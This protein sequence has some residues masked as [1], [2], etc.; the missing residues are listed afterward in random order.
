[1]EQREEVS[2]PSPIPSPPRRIGRREVLI[3]LGGL[4]AAGVGGGIWKLVAIIQRNFPAVTYPDYVAVLAWSHQG[5]HIAF[6]S[7]NNTVQ[8]WDTVTNTHLV[9]Y[10]GHTAS[11][12][13][14]AWSPN[15][16]LIAS[17]AGNDIRDNT[18]QV[19]NATTGQPLVTYLGHTELVNAVAW[20]PDGKR[21]ASASNDGTLQIWDATT[22]RLF[23]T[24]RGQAR[25]VSIVLWSPDGKRLVSDSGAAN[26]T[27]VWDALTGHL[28]L[29]GT[30][31][32]S[33]SAWGWSPDGKD[34]A[35]VMSNTM[36]RVWDTITGHQYLAHPANLGWTF[37][38]I[39][40]P[41]GKYIAIAANNGWTLQIQDTRSG[42]KVW[43]YSSAGF[44]PV[45]NVAWSPN[46]KYLAS[47]WRD[48]SVRLFNAP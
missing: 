14:L 8:V 37:A 23:F 3:G 19:W 25:S 34:L 48:G 9:T 11:I 22:G 21:I 18:V 20:S 13:A 38:G 44:D 43:S 7:L 41:I 32:D 39:W 47:G 27:Q 33:F 4:A 26:M 5:Q 29:A 1:M 10:R 12:H 17:G 31:T 35:L 16:Q 42:E 28:I 6:G 2:R 24:C 45:G 15:N 46:G 30:T 36:A 40:S